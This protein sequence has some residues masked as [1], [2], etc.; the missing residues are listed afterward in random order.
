MNIEDI[1]QK[2]EDE[3][4]RMQVSLR[5]NVDFKALFIVIG[6]LMFASFMTGLLS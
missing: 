2:I 5:P 1:E 6:L 4:E 3:L